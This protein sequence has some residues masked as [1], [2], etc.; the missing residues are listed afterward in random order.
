MTEPR[1]QPISVAAYQA[2]RRELA[3]REFI[4]RCRRR[5]V[6][7][8]PFREFVDEFGQQC[9]EHVA[10][11]KMLAAGVAWGQI[12]D[13][14][15]SQ[16]VHLGDETS[17]LSEEVRRLAG[18]IVEQGRTLR[19]DDVLQPCADAPLGHLSYA[20]TRIY[21]KDDFLY[22]QNPLSNQ[23]GWT[24]DADD[25]Y[26]Q[27]DG[28]YVMFVAPG[29]AGRRPQYR[30]TAWPMAGIDADYSVQ[31]WLYST[32]VSSKRRAMG[33]T[34]RNVDANNG[35]VLRSRADTSD[36]AVFR[37]KAGVQT[38]ISTSV[39]N[40]AN[41]AVWRAEILGQQIKIYV[42]AGNLNADFADAMPGG[43]DAAGFAGLDCF[44]DAAATG[45]AWIDYLTILTEGA[46][47]PVVGGSVV[48]QGLCDQLGLVR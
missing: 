11:A 3:R 36:T 30:W 39:T 44:E 4:D 17:V 18:V 12:A 22:T 1:T 25:A 31:T 24:A 23:A 5:L 9:R 19:W 37:R 34:W 46:V 41:P 35:Y 7:R 38:T 14:G 40:W 45:S 20:H 33:T 32:N 10:A 43:L 15:D 27:T 13:L 26:L 21:Q 42:G 2:G 47:R 8:V 48:G 29:A 6:L 28:N 16:L